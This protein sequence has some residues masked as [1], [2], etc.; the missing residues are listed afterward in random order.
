MALRPFPHITQYSTYVG[1]FAMAR[2]LFHPCTS[3]HAG[4]YVSVHATDFYATQRLRSGHRYMFTAAAVI[5]SCAPS[6]PFSL[7]T[8]IYGGLFCIRSD[9]LYLVATIYG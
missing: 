3:L 7:F 1:A 4:K 6:D 5:S 9:R 8:A 2:A